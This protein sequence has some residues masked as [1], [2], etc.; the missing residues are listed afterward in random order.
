VVAH[1][2]VAPLVV[3][4]NH[5]SQTGDRLSHRGPHCGLKTGLEGAPPR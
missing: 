3:C 1:R 4:S 2:I 5:T